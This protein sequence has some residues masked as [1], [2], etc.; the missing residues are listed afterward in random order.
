MEYNKES[1]AIRVEG[2][3]VSYMNGLYTR[4]GTRAGKPAYR[5]FDD[6][7]MEFM[8]FWEANR[9]VLANKFL[10]SDES[11]F[12]CLM[13][14]QKVEAGPNATSSNLEFPPESGWAAGD[15]LTFP[16][17]IES[18]WNT[19]DSGSEYLPTLSFVIPPADKQSL[20]Q[21][22]HARIDQ[23]VHPTKRQSLFLLVYR[24]FLIQEE[25]DL[26]DLTT[27]D[28]LIKQ[29]I[30]EEC[31]VS[32]QLAFWKA[33]ALLEMPEYGYLKSLE[34]RME[35]WKAQKSSAEWFKIQTVVKLVQTF[36]ETP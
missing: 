25:C 36:L 6:D 31:L 23:D 11:S 4:H 30:H 28:R 18:G 5:H 22:F 20:A 33:S 19:D 13:Y 27:I 12:T 1:L 8:I 9:W 14:Y 24:R 21:Q 17:E 26:S 2:P 3:T 10:G 15:L 16:D 7:E 35:G 29:S 32:L 34:W